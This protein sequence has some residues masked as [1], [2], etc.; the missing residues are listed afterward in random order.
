MNARQERG[1]KR[2][3]GGKGNGSEDKRMNARRERRREV[4]RWWR[5]KR[6]MMVMMVKRSA[7]VSATSGK[8]Q[9]TSQVLS[10]RTRHHDRDHHLLSL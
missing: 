6:G 7:L 2:G 10:F 1:W 4:E 9:S 5:G 3:R 8:K